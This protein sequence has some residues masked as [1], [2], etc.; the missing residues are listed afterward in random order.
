MHTSIM[1]DFQNVPL[2]INTNYLRHV[3]KFGATTA[4]EIIGATAINGVVPDA[5]SNEQRI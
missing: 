3:I 1:E 2:L 4:S 5:T